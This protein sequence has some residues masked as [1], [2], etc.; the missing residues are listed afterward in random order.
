LRR[1]LANTNAVDP[2]VRGDFIDG[3]AVFRVGLGDR[4]EEPDALARCR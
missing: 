4:A 2:R 3:K 1:F